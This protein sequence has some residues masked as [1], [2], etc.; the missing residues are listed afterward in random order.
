MNSLTQPQQPPRYSASSA[1]TVELAKMLVLVAP[2]SMTAEQQELWLRAAVD[3]LEDIRAN[4]VAEVSAQIR[5]SI[6]RPN[7]I[8]PAIAEKVAEKRALSSRRYEEQCYR[9]WEPQVMPSRPQPPLTQAE[10]Q[11]MPRWLQEVGL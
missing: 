7:Q 3:A 5:R 4:E 11:R 9:P 6:T 2:T 1:L 8:V 10:I